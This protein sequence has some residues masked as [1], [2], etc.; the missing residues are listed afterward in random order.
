MLAS[1]K[2]TELPDRK[3]T[4][5]VGGSKSFINI[6]VGSGED[7]AMRNNIEDNSFTR[8]KSFH[9]ET[10]SDFA[11]S[12]HSDKEEKKIK[13]NKTKKIRTPA[14]TD[15]IL[16]STTGRLH[17]LLYGHCPQ[18]LISDHKPVCSAFL[19]QVTIL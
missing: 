15:R 3:K 10:K 18:I 8:T 1:A 5:N 11:P 2:S 6:R 14:W 19:F 13:K 16:Y 9:L 7:L 4:H 17:Q 12:I